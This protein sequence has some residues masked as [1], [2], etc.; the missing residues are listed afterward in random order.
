MSM[1]LIYILFSLMIL[2][3]MGQ[4]FCGATDPL[5]AA[6]ERLTRIG[7]LSDK[8][9]T[10]WTELKDLAQF[11]K[12]IT[13]KISAVP[14]MEEHIK[15]SGSITLVTLCKFSLIQAVPPRQQVFVLSLGGNNYTDFKEYCLKQNLTHIIFQ[16]SAFKK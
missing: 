4:S 12:N 14:D 13:I 16:E 8:Q 6:S 11:T 9:N 1:K 5:E 3:G 2:L 7:G 15:D 10:Q